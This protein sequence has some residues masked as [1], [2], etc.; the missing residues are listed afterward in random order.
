M[1]TF[2]CKE[3]DLYVTYE[4]RRAPGGIGFHTRRLPAGEVTVYLTCGNDHVNPY[5]VVTGQE[6]KGTREK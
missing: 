4:P 3:C 6:E 1:Q 5:V 2:K